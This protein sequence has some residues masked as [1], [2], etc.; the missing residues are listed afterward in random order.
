MAE[1]FLSDIDTQTPVQTPAR[2]TTGDREP[3]RILISGSRPGIR[4]IIHTLHRL[5]FA[6]AHEWSQ[7][8]LDPHTGRL[9]SILTKFIMRQP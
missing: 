7:P 2:H 6:Q 9:M 3:V 5:G 1:E 8:Q 4:T